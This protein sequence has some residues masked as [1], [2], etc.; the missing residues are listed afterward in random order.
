MQKRQFEGHL[1]TYPQRLQLVLAVPLLPV[2]T[3]C[4]LTWWRFFMRCT[5]LSDSL[6]IVSTRPPMVRGSSLSKTSVSPF[7]KPHQMALHSRRLL[8]FCNNNNKQ[9]Q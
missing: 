6:V 4:C 7:M 8:P 2:A 5:C 9:E 1:H 3:L